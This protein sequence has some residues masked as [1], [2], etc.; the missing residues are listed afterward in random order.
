M[1]KSYLNH[2]YQRHQRFIFCGL[3]LPFALRLIYPFET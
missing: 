3:P 2:N 1:K